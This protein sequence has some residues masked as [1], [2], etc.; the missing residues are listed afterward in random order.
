MQQLV[1]LFSCS[2]YHVPLRIVTP[3]EALALSGLSEQWQR[4]S[5]DDAE[6]LTDPQIGDVPT[7]IWSALGDD[8]RLREW[9]IAVPVLLIKAVKLA[10]LLPSMKLTAIAKNHQPFTQKQ[11]KPEAS[12][13]GLSAHYPCLHEAMLGPAIARKMLEGGCFGRLDI[14]TSRKTAP[15]LS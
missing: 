15:A 11:W 2:T 3:V 8:Q 7:L 6:N 4:T 9:I 14:P 10:M 12:K 13:K 1:P 5:V